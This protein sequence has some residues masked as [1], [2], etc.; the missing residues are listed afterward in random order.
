MAITA[1]LVKELRDKTGA[2]MMDCKK[3]LTETD[4]NLD[5][6]VDWLREKGIAKAAKKQSRI[7]AEG[8]C[9]VLVDGNEAVIY[10]L[11]CET[12]FVTKNE[13]FDKLINKVGQTILASKATNLEEA[14]ELGVDGKKLSDILVD[15]TITIGEKINLR[16]VSRVVKT[17][18]DF[19]GAYKHMGGKIASLVVMN[20]TN[21][22]AAKDV[23][24]HVAAINPK[25][26]D[27]TQINEDVIAH[28]RQVLTN[29]ALNE[30]KPANI[31]EKMVV[32]RLNKYLKEICLVNQPFVKNPDLTVDK[33]V[34]ENNGKILSF[35]R[36]EVGE[37][38]EKRVDDF[39][40]EV[41]SQVNA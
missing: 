5:N 20:G 39:A 14:L 10:E 11:N 33:F 26:L 15:A 37:G 3:A 38:I 6:A 19:F 7:A 12:D 30:G 1:K 2:G 24:M 16:R 17:D 13:N 9:N 36:L 21:E 31:V 23:S 22:A 27:Q 34:K 41:M 29:E 18:S 35:I 8:L 4:G 25:Y 28:E 40:A 32:G